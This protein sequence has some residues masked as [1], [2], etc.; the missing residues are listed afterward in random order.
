MSSKDTLK[1]SIIKAG[2]ID[3]GVTYRDT[4]VTLTDT[5]KAEIAFTVCTSQ[6]SLEEIE[7]E[8]QQLIDTF[9]LELARLDMARST[10]LSTIASNSDKVVSGEAIEPIAYDTWEKDNVLYIVESGKDVREIDNIIDSI[11]I[12]SKEELL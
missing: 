4:K 5:Q 3:K 8:R 6:S 12:E 1:T 7:Q 9:N 10:L 11:T 2:Y